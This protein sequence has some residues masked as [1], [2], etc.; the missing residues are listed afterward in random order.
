MGV[1]EFVGNLAAI[2]QQKVRSLEG[3]GAF[4]TNLNKGKYGPNAQIHANVDIFFKKYTVP[5]KDFA[6]DLPESLTIPVNAG[7]RILAHYIQKTPE[8]ETEVD[9]ITLI[10]QNA[11]QQAAH[12]EFNYFAIRDSLHQDIKVGAAIIRQH[13]DNAEQA[14]IRDFPDAENAHRKQLLEELNERKQADLKAFND[15]LNNEILDAH[16]LAA[17]EEKARHE[18]LDNAQKAEQDIKELIKLKEALEQEEMPEGSGVTITES[19]AMILNGINL[20]D[21][22][23]IYTATGNKITTTRNED[24]SF[25]YEVAP[26]KNR[27]WSRHDSQYDDILFTTHLI[28]TKHST[29][30]WDVGPQTH[31]KDP[32]RR[33]KEEEKVARKVYEAARE[34]GFPDNAITIRMPAKGNE[35]AVIYKATPN[36][37]NKNEKSFVTLYESSRPKG[38]PA[39]TKYQKADASAQNRHDSRR[40]KMLGS[41]D[42]N[43]TDYKSDL[44]EFKKQQKQLLDKHTGSKAAPKR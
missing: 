11:R 5:I 20:G 32:A 8:I 24:G 21:L 31:I 25:S 37:A 30:I 36:P 43:S 6:Q 23:T 35:K 10:T 9:R 34:A 28:R 41:S 17:A 38:E 33:A 7:D 40:E 16:K 44:A 22:G 3:E 1:E 39:Q 14:I 13:Y 26:S 19:G 42:K 18:R 2:L 29:I 12:G 27:W 4:D 15:K